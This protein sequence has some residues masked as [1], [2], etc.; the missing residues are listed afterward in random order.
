MGLS[1]K[2]IGYTTL[3]IGSWT[4]GNG[5]LSV[6]YSAT[7]PTSTNIGTTIATFA[8]SGTNA[9]IDISSYQGGYIGFYKG[10][11]SL[12]GGILKNIVFS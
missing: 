7:A 5:G 2:N 9:T 3:K 6:R 1:V 10:S 11:S 8:A 4:G 12:A